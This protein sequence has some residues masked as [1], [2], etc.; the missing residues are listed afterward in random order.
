MA[1]RTAHALA[2]GRLAGERAPALDSG[3]MTAH[4]EFRAACIAGQVERALRRERARQARHAELAAAA[5]AAAAALRA[6]FGSELA[7]HVFGSVADA[8]RFRLDSDLDLAVRGIPADRYYEA[9]AVA[10]TAARAA[11]AGRVDLVDLDGAPH[12]LV[13]EVEARGAAIP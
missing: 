4:A 12:W 10:E 7:V 3:I 8:S 5:R 2:V 13:A 11:G 9:W 1:A 6:R